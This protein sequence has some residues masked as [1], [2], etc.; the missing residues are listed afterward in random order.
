MSNKPSVRQQ[1]EPILL[2]LVA[3]F[4]VGLIFPLGKL[5]GEVGIPP[6]LFAG[7]SA[8]GAS[9]VLATISTASGKPVPFDR[10][11]VSY[12]AVAGQLT[13]AVPFGLL[14]VVIPHVGSGIPAILQSLTPIITLAIVTAIGLER[15]GLPRIFG[16]MLGVAGAL[17]ILIAQN[18]AALETRAPIGWYFAA[19]ITPATLSAGNVYRTAR[20]PAD[21]HPL[22]L[23]TLTLVAAAIGLFLMIAAAWLMGQG[24][25]LAAPL[26]A[27][28]HLILLQSLATG[29][30]YAFFFRLQQVGGPLYLS[31]ISY[32]H[33]AVGVGFAVLL[34]AERLSPWIWLAL[35]LVLAGVA[36]VNRTQATGR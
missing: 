32:V 3:G 11:T 30:G 34:F 26:T 1:L 8:A 21:R 23:A 19:L 22:S 24:I 36:L 9:I 4:L 28:W 10:T 15:P 16:L 7:L 29:V 18:A 5:A 27:G 33:T 17:T 14:V 31:Q 13:F 20:W 25:E 12:A 35:V 6:L 2:L